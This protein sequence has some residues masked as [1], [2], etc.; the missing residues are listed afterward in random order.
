MK[1]QK[2]TTAKTTTTRATKVAAT[3]T[4]ATAKAAPA[5]LKAAPAPTKA[6]PTP[7]PGSK[8]VPSPSRDEI[9]K[10]AYEIFAGRGRIG[11]RET[12]DWIQAERELRAEAA[13]KN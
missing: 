4:L 1:T 3:A 13:R 5:A 10:R 7:T 11:G 9:A 6:A 8:V 12:E 2:K